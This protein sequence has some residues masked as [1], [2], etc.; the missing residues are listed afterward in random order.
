MSRIDELI[1]EFCPEGVEYMQLGAIEDTGLIK[2]GRGSVIS[3]KDIAAEPGDY[4]IYSSSASGVGEFGRYGKYMFD[5]ERLSWSVDGG[6]R[7]FYR[8]PHKYSV[9]NVS[10]WLKVLDS[11]RID[12]KYL[13]YALDSAWTTKKFD[14][15]KKAHPSVIRNEYKIPIPPLEVQKEIV[16]ILDKFTQLEAELSAEQETRKKQY[17]YYRD[18]LLTFDHSREDVKE[19]TLED[20]II[21]LKTGLNPRKNFVLNSPGA[22]NYYVTVRELN[23]MGITIFDKTDKVDDE[24]LRLISNRSKLAEGDVL[25]SGTGTIGRTALVDSKPANWNVKEGVYVIKPNADIIDPKYLLFY[26]NSSKAKI[27]YGN[28]VVGS[29]VSS[30]P[31]SELKRIKIVVPSLDEQSEIVQALDRFYRLANDVEVGLPAEINARRQQYEYYRT[32][33]LTF[34]E[35]SV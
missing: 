33:L 34:Q 19:L 12:I 20:V 1:Q 23:G 5:D 14:Y 17:E 11:S 18:L 21:S 27:D 22:T 32:K 16:N 7:F 2:L 31:M 13:F 29:P 26:L 6:G 35:L 25:F 4:P 8:H 3:K 10:G 24:G 30:V 9:T 28:R 15:T